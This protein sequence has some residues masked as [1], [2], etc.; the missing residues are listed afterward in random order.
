MAE[1]RSGHADRPRAG[2]QRQDHLSPRHARLRRLQRRR[3]ARSARTAACPTR[4]RRSSIRARP[5]RSSR[6]SKAWCSAAPALR[7][8]RSASRSP[9]RPAPRTIPRTHG[10]SASRPIWRAACSSAST[11]RARSAAIEQGATAAAPI[12]RDFMKGALDG[13]PPTPFRIPA[14]IDLVTIDGSTG[15]LAA[16]R[17]ARRHSG[18][19]QGGNRARRGRHDRQSVAAR[20]PARP[21]M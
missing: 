6:C 16:A 20:T 2:S 8:A 11:I 19:L 9:A 4:A 1:R 10:S 21:A 14:G 5:I 3:V 13:V 15:Q 7:C 18:S 12:F 17:L